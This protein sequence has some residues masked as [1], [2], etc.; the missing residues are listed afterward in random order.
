MTFREFCE[1]IGDG[2]LS[3]VPGAKYQSPGGVREP[4]S[5]SL[6][7]AKATITREQAGWCVS[8][9]RAGGTVAHSPMFGKAMDDATAGKVAGTIAGFLI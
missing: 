4:G 8:F 6:G 1:S 9:S 5:V 3:C 2:V 7:G